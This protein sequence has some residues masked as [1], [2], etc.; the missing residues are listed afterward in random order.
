MNKL[1]PYIK[2]IIKQALMEEVDPKGLGRIGI[3]TKRFPIVKDALT[4]LMSKS[5]VYYIKDIRI[6]SPKPTTF[7]IILKNG[8]DFNLIYNGAK[9]D[10]GFIAKISGKRYDLIKLDDSQRAINA[11]SDLLSL[12][13]A[14]K[15]DQA[16]GEASQADAGA[17]AYNDTIG[18]GG[19]GA[20]DP[21][22]SPAMEVPPGTEP[23]PLGGETSP[24]GEEIG[25]G[26]IKEIKIHSRVTPEMIIQILIDLNKDYHY[27]IEGYLEKYGYNSQDRNRPTFSEF[28]SSLP[29]QQLNDLYKEF[30]NI[31]PKEVQENRISLKEFKQY[32]KKNFQKLK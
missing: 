27:D 6:I 15:E 19:G 30:L 16:G 5:F 3:I 2:E 26:E 28:I 32:F 24:P 12:S 1:K 22:P 17:A 7:G 14:V 10:K 11:I 18:G 21:L 20:I 4:R 25:G 23:V 29:Q 8:L 31:K 9:K 13:P